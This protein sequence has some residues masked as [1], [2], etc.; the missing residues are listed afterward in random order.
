MLFYYVLIILCMRIKFNFLDLILCGYVL[1]ENKL[2][3]L[4]GNY[5]V[6]WT[7]EFFSEK[8]NSMLRCSN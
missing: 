4:L 7:A 1:A 2:F 6:I 5:L 3:K 8:N